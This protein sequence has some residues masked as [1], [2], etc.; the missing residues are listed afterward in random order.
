MA[1]PFALPTYAE[2][3]ASQE[4]WAKVKV[5]PLH[6]SANEIGSRSD[7]AAVNGSGKWQQQEQGDEQ[8]HRGGKEIE[9]E[10]EGERRVARQLCTRT[11][12]DIN[13]S[14]SS[15][16]LVLLLIKLQICRGER[17]EERRA[18]KVFLPA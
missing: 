9:S 15:M 6:I 10:R 11:G 14:A 5:M 3:L 12:T 1:L 2:D 17:R 16:Q 4:R 13:V 7:C 18:E 8:G